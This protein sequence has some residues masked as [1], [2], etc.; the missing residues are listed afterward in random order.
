MTKSQNTKNEQQKDLCITSEQL[1]EQW[2][3]GELPYGRYYVELAYNGNSIIMAEYWWDKT[4]T[5]DDHKYSR[6]EVKRILA[7]VPSYNEWQANENYID[8]LKQCISVYE[9]KDKQ[10][11]ETSIAYNELAKENEELKEILERHKKATAKA[12]I[13]SC[14]LEIINTQLK[15]LLKKYKKQLSENKN[16]YIDLTTQD[17][18]GSYYIDVVKLFVEIVGKT[19][20]DFNEHKIDNAIG[21]KK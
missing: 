10:A 21:E 17:E 1:T 2:K 5:L 16:A 4:L 6:E 14:D 12:Q 3:K 11:T 13:R 9:S 7:P 15:E 20:K 18:Y 8:Y 19:T